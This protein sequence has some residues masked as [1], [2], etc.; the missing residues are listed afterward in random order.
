VEIW[1]ADVIILRVT[2]CNVYNLP[3]NEF[4]IIYAAMCVGEIMNVKIF[5]IFRE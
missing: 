5:F 3:G 4:H 2:S 1:L